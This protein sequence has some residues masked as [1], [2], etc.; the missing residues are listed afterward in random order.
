MLVQGQVGISSAKLGEGANA[1]IAQGY[2]GELLKSDLM[3]RYYQLAKRGFLFHMATSSVTIVAANASPL[4]AGTGQPIAGLWNPPNSG[5]DL[6]ICKQFFETIS[7]TPGGGL[8]WNFAN[9]PAITATANGVI[10]SAYLGS[11]GRSAARGFVN[12]ALTGAPLQTL[13]RHAEAISAVAAGAS[14]MEGMED[15]AGDI[16]IP[17]GVFAG[18]ASFATGTSHIVQASLSWAEIPV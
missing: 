7:G 15:L 12:T 5:V 13:L 18:V 11:G 9:A 10:N 4:A 3:A 17:P 16:I 8:L 6:V 14:T 1:N 2:Q